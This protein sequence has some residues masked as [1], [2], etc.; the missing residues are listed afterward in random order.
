[1]ATQNSEPGRVFCTV[2][3]SKQTL[4]NTKVN[5]WDGKS[6]FETCTLYFKE[7]GRQEVSSKSAGPGPSLGQ[8]CVQLEHDN[9]IFTWL[10]IGFPVSQMSQ[11]T[12]QF[13]PGTCITVTFSKCIPANS[14][15]ITFVGLRFGIRQ[16]SQMNI[17]V[18]GACFAMRSQILYLNKLFSSF[19]KYVIVYYR[20]RKQ[21]QGDIFIRSQIA[22]NHWSWLNNPKEV[23]ANTH[24]PK[25]ATNTHQV[26]VFDPT[27]QQ[28][29]IRLLNSHLLGFNCWLNR[30]VIAKK[31]RAISVWR[32]IIWS[33][34]GLNCREG[35]GKWY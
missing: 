12:R 5:L 10:L 19:D 14:K 21:L 15:P 29:R 20:C 6:K 25:P 24:P 28:I 3:S 23:E 7:T 1:M 22:L 11:K 4:N 27:L 35:E 30:F 26:T 16:I 8:E 9:V 33:P 2:L 31:S 13:K 18:K 34:S 32:F 17:S